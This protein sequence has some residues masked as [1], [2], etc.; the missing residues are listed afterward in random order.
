M[1][2][3]LN[4]YPARDRMAEVKISRVA[5][6]K[7]SLKIRDSLLTFLLPKDSMHSCWLFIIALESL[8]LTIHNDCLQRA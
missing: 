5:K 6:V 7:I 1:R 8:V 2:A 4:L 3:V